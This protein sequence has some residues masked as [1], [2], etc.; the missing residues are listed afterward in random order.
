MHK[1]KRPRWKLVERATYMKKL[2]KEMEKQANYIEATEEGTGK[3]MGSYMM[4]PIDTYNNVTRFGRY[5]L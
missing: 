5:N 2:L 3:V 1:I 4:I